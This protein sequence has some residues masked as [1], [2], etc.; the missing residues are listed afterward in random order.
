MTKDGEHFSGASQSFGIPQLTILCLT[1]SPF[2][3]RLFDF[4]ESTFM[5]SFYNLDSSPLSDLGLVKILSHSV[6]GF[7]L[8]YLQCLLPYRSFAIL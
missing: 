4:L 3:M 8:S 6:G 7:F 2:L 1:L 5:S